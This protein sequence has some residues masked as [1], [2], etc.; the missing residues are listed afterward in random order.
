MKLRNLFVL[1]AAAF[2][3]A[4]LG[5]LFVPQ[6]FMAAYGVELNAA[7]YGFVRLYGAT[8]LMAAVVYYL[9]AGA[10]SPEAQRALTTGA[11]V[12]NVLAAIVGIGNYLSGEY[13]A[14]SWG[15]IAIWLLFAAGF[16]YFQFGRPAAAAQ[17]KARRS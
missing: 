1:Q 5:S 4:G 8:V 17:P 12:G 7:G 9:G 11:I 3:L 16:A 6:Q 13:N 14:L 15:S 2:A 10:A